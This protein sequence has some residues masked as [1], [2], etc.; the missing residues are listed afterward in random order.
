MK[1]FL[2]LSVFISLSSLL[3]SQ[4]PGKVVVRFDRGI[5]STVNAYSVSASEEKIKGFRVQLCSESGNNARGVAN[6]VKANFLRQF[7]GVAA[8]LIWESP[9]F[10]VRVGDFKNRLDATLFWKQI[11]ENFPQAYVVADEVNMMKI[12]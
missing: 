5:E 12:D 9:N 1:K 4:Q 3:F 11:I 8:Y 10:K 2:V 6:S 7:D